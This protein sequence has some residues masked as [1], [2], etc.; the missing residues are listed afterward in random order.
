MRLRN[1]SLLRGAIEISA[2]SYRAL[3]EATGV[4]DTTISLLVAGRRRGLS[5]D[6]AERLCR[7]LGV[8]L[9]LLFQIDALD[10]E[11]V[12]NDDEPREKAS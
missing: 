3:E 9:Q 7:E 2:K 8:D 12:T 1:P 6:K 11:T 4:D 5:D 10:E